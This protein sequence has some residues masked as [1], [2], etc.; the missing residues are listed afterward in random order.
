MNL[1]QLG[2]F[3]LRSGAKSKWKICCEALSSDDWAALAQMAAEILPPFGAVEGVPRGGIPFAEALQ[4]H[5]LPGCRTLLIAE[6]VA[7]TGGSLERHRV[8][9]DAIGV[10][11]F[12]RE[13]CPLWVRPLFTMRT[14]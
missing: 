8:G 12:C 5:V 10:V 2:N 7:T 4:K 14:S 11:V 13:Y 6:D 1:F 3:T 9:R